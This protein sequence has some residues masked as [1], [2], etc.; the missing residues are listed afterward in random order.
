MD[1]RTLRLHTTLG[2]E[3]AKGTVTENQP[4][5]YP[6]TIY[7]GGITDNSNLKRNLLLSAYAQYYKDFNKIHHFDIMGGYEY[8][9][10]SSVTTKLEDSTTPSTSLMQE[11]SSRILQTM[12]NTRTSSYHSSVVPTIH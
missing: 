9:H 12:R 11:K 1:L 4:T 6:S 5:S 7:Y 2:A 8:Q 3:V 10:F